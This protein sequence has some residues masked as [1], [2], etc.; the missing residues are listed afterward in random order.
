MSGKIHAVILN[1]GAVLLGSGIIVAV[2]WK[3]AVTA[4]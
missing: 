2:L 3:L 4:R 1:V